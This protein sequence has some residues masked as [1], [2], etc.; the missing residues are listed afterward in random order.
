MAESGLTENLTILIVEDESIVALDLQTSLESMGYTVSDV[1]FNGEEAI[2]SVKTDPPDLILMDIK[3]DP[4]L[5]GIEAANMINTMDEI[6]IVYVTASSDEATLLRIIQ[7]HAFGYVRK[8]I[9]YYDL[10]FAIQLG[11]SMY[12]NYVELKSSA[13]MYQDIFKCCIKGV[14]VGEIVWD[15]EESPVDI[16]LLEV[17]RAFEKIIGLSADTL[18]NTRLSKIFPE[19]AVKETIRRYQRVIETGNPDHFHYSIPSSQLDLDLDTFP[20]GK[21]RFAAVVVSNKN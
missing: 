5:D 21:S 10:Q 12:R 15:D 13:S 16:Q 4:N 19:D 2:R 6:P 11:Y 20:V 7:S 18:V 14:I 8:P 3:L 9:S 1:V 17:N